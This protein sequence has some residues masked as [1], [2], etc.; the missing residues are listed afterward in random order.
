VQLLII[1]QVNVVDFEMAP[2]AFQFALRGNVELKGA[3]FPDEA[4]LC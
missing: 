3:D 2:L 4:I 1:P